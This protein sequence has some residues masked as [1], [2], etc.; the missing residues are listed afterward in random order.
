MKACR[1][2]MGGQP[3]TISQ[4][5]GYFEIADMDGVRLTGWCQHNIFRKCVKKVAESRADFSLRL[6]G[7]AIE[8]LVCSRIQ[9][10]FLARTSRSIK[11]M[12]IPS[13][14]ATTK[15]LSI[16]SSATSLSGDG[17]H[18]V[19][20]EFERSTPRKNPP[21]QGPPPTAFRTCFLSF[22]TVC[23]APF[24]SLL[25]LDLFSS[26]K[27]TQYYNRLHKSTIALKCN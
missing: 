10:Q 8:S 3:N 21:L 25:S 6:I 7:V 2:A 24:R 12:E 27:A 5:N 1:S 9:G 18:G 23:F 14:Q 20:S 16:D 13:D 15:K 22:P 17:E 26:S 19:N 4:Q 11:A